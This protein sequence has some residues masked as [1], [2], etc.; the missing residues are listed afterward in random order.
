MYQ[1]IE[2]HSVIGDLNTV[3]LVALDGTI[4]FMCLPDFDSPTIFALLLDDKRGGFFRI[5]PVRGEY[6][7]RQLYLP[8]SNILLTRFL[9]ET[10]VA[11]ILDF[12]P[13]EESGHEHAIV[14]RVSVVRGEVRLRMTCAPRFDYARA[15]H[16]IERSDGCV[17]FISSG[18]DDVVLCLRTSA[19]LRVADGDATC[20]FT[21]RAG[22]AA[23]FVL[24][25]ADGAESP[26]ASPDFVSRSFAE[27][28]AFW[29]RWIARSNYRGRWREMV[30]RSALVLK[31]LTSRSHGSVVAA[32][33]FG[34]P[35]LIGGE[36]NW[37]YRYAWVRDSAF[38][39]YCLLQLGYT[40]EATAFIKWIHARCAESNGQAKTSPLRL[41]YRL[42]G[43]S[44]LPEEIL[45]HLEG[46]MG[47]RPVRIGNGATDQLQLDIYGELMDAVYL[48]DRYAEPVSYDLWEDLAR[49]TN[50]VC[51]HW[52]A[53]DQSI[54]EVR[55][56]G[57]EFTFS[58]LM[59]WT[60][61]DR[62]ARIAIARSLPA[63]LDRW[64]KTRD[65]IYNELHQHYFSS[66]RNAFVRFRGAQAMDASTLL[67]P[68][69][70]FISPVDPRWLS[71]IRAIEEDLV[72]DTLVHRYKID[73]QSAD[74]L[75]GG[76]GTF[77]LC[78]FWYV[79]SLAR[80]G[81]V[82][83]ARLC[84][85]K[86]LSYANHTGLYAEQ[87]GVQGI[88]LGNF[89]QALTHLSLISAAYDLDRNLERP[90]RTVD[91]DGLLLPC[92]SAFAS[93]DRSRR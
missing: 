65:E 76:E 77:S 62:A 91:E 50:W 64:L 83:R 81:H 27:T 89:P 16:R 11:E 58:R 1:P 57:R 48:H 35:E 80:A 74:G 9:S 46:Y 19:P 61:I 5:A 26:A 63:P 93:P 6:N 39:V 30:N 51:A 41:V 28:A 85:E 37:D 44:H 60:A 18:A 86:M 33:T 49:L 70:K 42:D 79:E 56:G 8:D 55:G 68:L 73:D 7:K 12:M 25:Q 54:W 90:T 31:L 92:R 78:S 45:P 14:R 38:T 84:F 71:T 10:G 87:L 13:V 2:N 43:S 72:C 23:D 34:L 22:Q 21:L 59:C 67:M 20:E 36:R 29:H 75:A 53:K 52:R 69:V 32:P 82:R 88:H 17:R 4:D 15:E 24:E 40:E 66:Q 47:S 3:A